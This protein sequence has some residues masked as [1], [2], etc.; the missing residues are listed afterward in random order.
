MKSPNS[1]WIA[2]VLVLL[3][4]SCAH[5]A[6]PAYERPETPLKERWNAESN[7]GG[8]PL[9]T[10][11]WTQFGDSRLDALVESALAGNFDLRVAAG[12]VERAQALTGAADARRLPTVGVAAG[13]NVGRQSPDGGSSV[14]TEAYDL[15]VGFNWEID[16]WGKLRKGSEAA[17]AEY[18]ASGADWR[19]AY[20]VLVAATA[21]QYFGLRRLDGMLAIYDRFIENARRIATVYEAQVAENYVGRDT[22]LRQRAEVRRLERERQD[23]LRERR[24][25]ENAL[26]VL[27]GQ[28]AG[29]LAVPREAEN[30]LQPVAVPGGLP[31]DLLARRPDVL[32]A[33]YRVLAAYNLA[34]KARL[35]RLPSISLTANGGLASTALSDLLGQW[36]VGVGP[37]ISIPL[38]DAGRKA[39]VRVREADLEIAADQ[40]RGT[41]VKAFQEVEDTLVN[42]ASRNTQQEMAAG[43]VEDLRRVQEMGRA[44]FDEGLVSQ[45]EVLETERGLLQGELTSLNVRFLLLGDNVALFKALGGGWDA[46]PQP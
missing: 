31:A 40:Y 18:Q 19:G 37:K 29:E 28:A 22:L 12:R 17:E 42:L 11:W 21:N 8:A 25:A 41:V 45:L 33:E 13:A 46:E 14:Q 38:F 7:A 32:A 24:L 16:L 36:L 3:G 20:L 26:A 6:G 35:D 15:G 39:E 2:T 43:A 23:L 4:A 10:N 34:G 1:A 44:K 9:Q 5:V 30:R 27:T